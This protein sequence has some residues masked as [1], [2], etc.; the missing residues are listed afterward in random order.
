[1]QTPLPSLVFRETSLLTGMPHRHARR[2]NCFLTSSGQK[3]TPAVFAT[4][5]MIPTRQFLIPAENA[6]NAAAHHSAT[7]P[8]QPGTISITPKSEGWRNPDLPLDQRLD[9]LIGQLTPKQTDADDHR[10]A[11]EDSDSE[12]SSSEEEQLFSELQIE[13]TVSYRKFIRWFSTRSASADGRGISDE[14]LQTTMQIWANVAGHSGVCSSHGLNEVLLQMNQHGLLDRG[15]DPR[16]KSMSRQSDVG[17]SAEVTASSPQSP[18]IAAGGPQPPPPPPE[19]HSEQQCEQQEQRLLQQRLKKQQQQKEEEDKTTNAA[20]SSTTADLLTACTESAH[21]LFS[22][23]QR[24]NDELG[25][26]GAKT[27]PQAQP[28]LPQQQQQQEQEQQRKL[29]HSAV[30]RRL[31]SELLDVEAACRNLRK[32]FDEC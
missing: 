31:F 13:G 2:E 29:L 12:A 10:R 4:S 7:E 25:V 24:S 16:P 9:S 3:R 27:T 6:E 14:H 17:E 21:H 30:G 18:V 20:R 8:R 5:G 1:M 26:R 11:A 19:S 32:Q 23:L 22:L 15:F 28:P